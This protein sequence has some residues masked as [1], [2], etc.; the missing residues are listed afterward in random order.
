MRKTLLFL[1]MLMTA[2]V[3]RAQYEGSLKPLSGITY[4]AE[5]QASF[6]DDKTPLWLNAN[7]YGL[8]SLEKDNGYIRGALVRPLE[9]DSGRRWGV[10]YG[11]DLAVAY[12]YTS[13]AIVQ[14]AYAEGRWLHG[15]LTV[16]SKEFPMELKNNRLSSGAQT[17]GINA[18]PVPQVR[19]ALRDY[20]TLPILRGWVHLKGHVAYGKTTDDAWQKKFTGKT[21]KYTED[22]L[23]HSKAGYLKIGNEDI[24]FPLS[25]E[26][27]LEMACMFGGT[28]YTFQDGEMTVLK[29]RSNFEAYYRALIPGGGDANEKGTVYMNEEGNHLGSWLFRINY[30]AERWRLSVYADKFFEDHSAML[31]TDYDGYGE[32][33]EWKVK[34]KHRFLLYDFKD[35]MLGI[36][37]NLKQARWVNNIVAEYLYTKYQSG[38]VYHDHNSGL[39]DHIGGRDNFYNHGISTGWQ[40]WGQVIGNPLY[41]SPIY[42][43]DGTIY[44]KNNRFMAFHL[45]FD[46]FLSDNLTYRALVSWQQGLG[47]YD[48]PY[49]KE[50]YNTSFLVEAEYNFPGRHLR[51][52]SLRGDYGMD[53]GKIRGNNF[54]FQLTITKKGL[55]THRAK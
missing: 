18:R 17:L 43:E 30:D 50:L 25:V 37:L 32:G 5:A 9:A 31:Q 51:G 27:G 49:A 34:K 53:F 24:F 39:S 1:V 45:G 36:E 15:V 6:S 40:H 14:Q 2:A 47:T 38:P 55:L 23:F 52:W 21:S 19:L 16:G 13:T 3:V 7:K 48:L 26:M 29:S 46:G 44:V 28:S 54:G 8:S 10:G 42:N 41:L 22:V 12:D 4:K 20:W 35:W 33:D 11:L